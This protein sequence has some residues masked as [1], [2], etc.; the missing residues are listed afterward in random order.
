MRIK[1]NTKIKELLDKYPEANDIL[2]KFKMGSVASEIGCMGCD[3][4]EYETI[5]SCADLHKVDLKKLLSELN[6]FIEKKKAK[7]MKEKEMAKSK[8]A[9]N[10]NH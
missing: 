10:L 5:Q 9:R 1:R 3:A 2:I 8:K 6:K 7:K 4:A